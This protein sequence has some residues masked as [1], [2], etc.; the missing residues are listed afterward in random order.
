MLLVHFETLSG[1]ELAVE[2]FEMRLADGAVGRLGDGEG[3][4]AG[5]GG[6]GLD[7]V[8]VVRSVGV[9]GLGND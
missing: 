2:D 8:G 7:D 1:G 5:G 4:E 3:R 6:L 9:G